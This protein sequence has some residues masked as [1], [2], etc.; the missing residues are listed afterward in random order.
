MVLKEISDE[1]QKEK[2]SLP[3][4]EQVWSELSAW[5]RETFLTTTD[6]TPQKEEKHEIV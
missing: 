5:I 3:S 2:E 4:A 6:Y 1:M